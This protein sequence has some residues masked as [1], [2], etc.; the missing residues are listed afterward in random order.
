MPLGGEVGRRAGADLVPALAAAAAG[1]AAL[2]LGARLGRVPPPLVALATAASAAAGGLLLRR[3]SDR[4]AAA[5]AQA[6]READR[7]KDEF[8]AMLAHELRNPLAPILNAVEIMRLCRVD[9]PLLERQRDTIDRQVLNLKRLLDDLLD[10]SRVSRGAIAL[11]RERVE[12]AAVVEQAVEA[13][14][15]LAAAK[16]HRLSV[17]LP[18]SPVHLWADGARL[19]QVLTNLLHNAVEYTDPGGHVDLAATLDGPEVVVRIRDDGI[20]MTP[21]TLAS[22]F[23]L[24]VQG[25]RPLDRAQGG[26]GI[27]LTLA[28]R[29]VELHG[30]SLAATSAGPCRGSE[31]TVRLPVAA[32]SGEGTVE[33]SMPDVMPV[34]TGESR[35][36]AS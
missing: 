36:T 34:L 23:D 22:A 17:S 16:G 32:P 19:A 30:G 13:T 27:G 18:S 29:L 31:L 3:G 10:V 11:H 14:A 6:L 9:D 8:L 25:K 2:I 12:L 4:A 33:G 20:G 28:R 15:P 21:E 7:R 5:R 35:T 24:F 26:L 1:G